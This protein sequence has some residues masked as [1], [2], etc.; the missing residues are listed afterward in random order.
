[1]QPEAPAH[2]SRLSGP[3]RALRLLGSMFDPRAWAHM[4]K[5]VNYYNYSHVQPMRRLRPGP[6]G[7]ISPNAFFSYPERIEIGDRVRISARCHIWAGPSCGRIVLSDDVL[8]AP[9]V[10]MTAANYRFND[11]QPVNDQ[12]MDEADIIVG[13]DV[14]IGYGAVILPGAR[15]GDGAI[16]GAGT[17]VRG[18]VEPFAIISA[19]E[20]SRPV[21]RRVLAGDAVTLDVGANPVVAEI[22]ARETPQIAAE[23]RAGPLDASGIDSFDLMTLRAAIESATGLRVPDAEWGGLASLDD[24]AR[25]PALTGAVAGTPPPP[26]PGP[27][28]VAPQPQIQPQTQPQPQPLA[29]AAAGSAV[30]EPIEAPSGPIDPPPPPPEIPQ[31]RFTQLTHELPAGMPASMIESRRPGHLHRRHILEM[32]KM[33][34]AGMGEPWLFRELNDLHWTQ[35]CDFLQ[36]PSSQVADDRGDRLYATITRCRIDFTPSLFAFKE[37][38]PLDI[39]SHL[40]RYGAAVFF[41]QNAFQGAP[42][43]SGHATVMSTFAKYGERGK[44]TSLIKG[45]PPL[46]I[47]EAVPPM[48]KISEFGYAY[49]ARRAEPPYDSVLYET[50]YEIQGPHDINGVGLLYFAAY[51]MIYDLCLERFEGKGFLR[52][53]STQSKDLFYF[54]NSEPSETLLF[55][56]HEREDLG[57]GRI[58]H[59]CSLSRTSDGARMG[60][61]VGIKINVA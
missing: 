37:N 6:G 61:M 29:Q 60:E 35:V 1:M 46:P 20:A 47:P 43:V 55:R 44:N 2:K 53:H 21:G 34:L 41:S 45:T 39:R 40:E 17:V 59:V 11:G 28:I 12:P 5:I 58:R 52:E 15:I 3:A 38:T 25:L 18:T 31:D 9:E 49:R 30:P 13:K 22:V 10:M 33:A 27:A 16:I 51:P 23:R 57:D 56:V 48:E 8:I 42:G 24:I 4:L 14:W 32:P 36:Q 26:A 50:E 7:A 54:A 19:S